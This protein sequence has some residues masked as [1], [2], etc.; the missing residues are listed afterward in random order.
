MLNVIPAARPLL[1][2]LDLRQHIFGPSFH[3]KVGKLAVRMV[4]DAHFVLHDIEHLQYAGQLML[5]QQA[6][7]QI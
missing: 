3:L 4:F 5:G 6:D 1:Q 2:A 7:V